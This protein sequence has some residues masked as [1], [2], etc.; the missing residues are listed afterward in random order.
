MKRSTGFVERRSLV[1]QQQVE[2]LKPV[3]D[4]LSPMLSADCRAIDR[5]EIAGKT[6]IQRTK[7]KAQRSKGSVQS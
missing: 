5:A 4:E 2:N 3:M 6:K 7:Y 1:N